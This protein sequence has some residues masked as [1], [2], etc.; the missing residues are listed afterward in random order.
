MARNSEVL[1]DVVMSG[2]RT[3]R[4]E[5]DEMGYSVEGLKLRR[6]RVRNE[7]FF[8]RSAGG[9]PE[10]VEDLEALLEELRGLSKQIEETEHK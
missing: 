1:E 2:R 10:R 3:V 4:P 8:N 6:M 5:R 9:G 7:I